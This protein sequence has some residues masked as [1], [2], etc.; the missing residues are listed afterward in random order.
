MRL[1]VRS[2]STIRRRL[3]LSNWYVTV[4]PMI[5][6]F[7]ALSVVFLMDMREKEIRQTRTEMERACAE[8]DRWLDLAAEALSMLGLDVNVQNAMSRYAGAALKEQLDYRDFFRNRLAGLYP[9]NMQ[10]VNAAI[11]LKSGEKSFSRD[12]QDAD[13]AA[14]FAHDPWFRELL[15]GEKTAYTGLGSGMTSEVQVIR[16]ARGIQSM[17]SGQVLG[18]GYM[19]LSVVRLTRCFEPMTAGRSARLLLGDALSLGG[20]PLSG[21]RYTVKGRVKALDMDVVCHVASLELS[22]ALI[23]AFACF[24]CG[25]GLLMGLVYLIDKRLAD[26]FARRILAQVA[27]A[28]RMGKGDFDIVLGD[29]ENDEIGELS[30]SLEQTAREMKR[31][32]EEKY[33]AE[34]Q[35][36]Q[37]ALHALQSQINPHFI[38]NTLERISMLAL[39]HDRYE[40]VGIV[41][42]FS[43]MMRYA[44]A[45][46]ALV[47][48]EEEIENV[49]HYLSIQRS[50]FERPFRV[51]YDLPHGE[52]GLVLP[53]LTLQPL[54][55]N[56]FRHGFDSQAAETMCLH[57]AVRKDGSGT[58]VAVGNNGQPISPKRI[59]EIMR[60]LEVPLDRETQDCFALR[61]I[62]QRLRLIYGRQASLSICSENGETWVRL[63]LPGREDHDEHS[64]P[65]LRR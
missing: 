61:N 33:L 58:V 26:F 4:I 51:Q 10:M 46:T 16:L 48:L 49:R 45:P 43:S 40:I 53:R 59:G 25:L 7:A 11:Y 37:A 44:I 56:A 13:L 60:L 47:S 21:V 52:S 38:F 17:R 31:L 9:S 54:V 8:A 57:L 22:R 36:Q 35:H 55:E 62:S 28:R 27:A 2:G 30:R 15:S 64:H 50:R 65:D 14:F 63:W 20:D 6:L 23:T 41:Q 29:A 12:Y 39:I 42:S 32:I 3:T 19:E 24:F 1:S 5:C 34:I 18:L